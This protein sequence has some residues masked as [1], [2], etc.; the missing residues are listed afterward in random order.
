MGLKTATQPR[1]PAAPD[2]YDH[3]YMEQLINVS[4]LVLLRNLT[5][6]L[7]LCLPLRVSGLLCGNRLDLRPT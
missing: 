5:T 1:L 6:L 3:Q 2:Q 4:A 7:Q